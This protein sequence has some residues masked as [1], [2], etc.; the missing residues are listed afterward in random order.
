[1]S[2]IFYSIVLFILLSVLF[3][4]SNTSKEFFFDFLIIVPLAFSGV[5]IERILDRQFDKI[6]LILCLLAVC[7]FFLYF[8]LKRKYLINQN[9]KKINKINKKK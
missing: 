5:A 2:L 6:T 7:F 4:F 1:M 9:I 3:Y 8:G